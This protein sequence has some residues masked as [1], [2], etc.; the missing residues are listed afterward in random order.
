VLNVFVVQAVAEP[1][2]DKRSITE[3]MFQKIEERKKE[4]Q[5]GGAGGA[6]TLE[7]LRRM[8]GF[9]SELKR[10]PSGPQD[11]PS[12]ITSTEEKLSKAPEFDVTVCGGTLGIFL[13]TALQ[14]KGLKV[15]VLERGKLAGRSQEWNIS[16][17]EM[18]ALVDLGVLTHD[19]IESS[20]ATEFNPVRMQFK[21][22][23]CCNHSIHHHSSCHIGSY[24]GSNTAQPPL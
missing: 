23:S 8:D 18:E 22:G 3:K 1:Q 24:T 17:D 20:I 12:F 21:V 15:S 11:V 7:A 4:S 6:T 16:R 13:A 9:W 14:L 2:V 10:R 19:E 5:A